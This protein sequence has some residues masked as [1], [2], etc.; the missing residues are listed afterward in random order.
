MNLS[1]FISK[2]IGKPESDTFSSTIHKVAVASVGLGLA[3]MIIAFLVLLGFQNNIKDKIYSF[4]GHIIITKHVRGASFETPPVSTNHDIFKYPENF[5][6]VDHI[7]EFVYKPGLIKT[8]EEV[9]GVVLKGVGLSYYTARFNSY[10]IEGTFVHFD[11]ANYS[12]DVVLSKHLAQKLLLKVGDKLTMYFMQNP[13]R[14]RRLTVS[15]IYETGLEDFDQKVIIGD[16]ALIQRLNN[17]PDTL[18]GGYEIFIDDIDNIDAADQY[19]FENTHHEL[20]VKKAAD[21]YPQVFDWLGILD[22]NVLIVLVI[23]LFVA[24]SNMISIVIILIMERTQMI[25]LLKA[26]GAENRLIRRV[27]TYTGMSLIG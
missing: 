24:G 1:Y 9:E 27:F 14:A 15:G 16:I 25:G 18:V 6:Y 19:L 20:F 2:R 21:K 7:Q 3:V 26:M 12:S 10:L 5:D 8:E 22:T 11:S 17:W 23:I 4:G 13:P